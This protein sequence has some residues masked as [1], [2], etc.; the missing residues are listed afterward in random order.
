MSNRN[1]VCLPNL[2]RNKRVGNVEPEQGTDRAAEI[3]CLSPEKR[4]QSTK[5]R[6]CTSEDDELVEFKSVE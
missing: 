2:W 5:S 4:C 1:L 3:R 6:R